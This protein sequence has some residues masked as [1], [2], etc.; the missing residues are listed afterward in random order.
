ML[1]AHGDYI[2]PENVPAN[3]FLNLEG[4]KISTSRNWA[5][6][7]HEYLVDFVDQQDAL[8][9]VLTANAPETKDNDFAWKD[10]QARNNNELLAILGNFVNRV[11]VLT[12]KYYGGK[13]PKPN[14]LL[15]VDKAILDEIVNSKKQVEA[16]L[17]VFRFRDALKEAMN[18][19]RAGNKYLTDTEP[20]KMV[21]VDP[22]RVKT[23]MYVCLQVTANL[24]VICEPFLPFT[25]KKI[26]DFLGIHDIS[27]KDAGKISFLSEGHATFEP[28]LL[29]RKIEDAE[30]Q[31]QVDK[32]HK[33]KEESSKTASVTPQ[34]EEVTFDDFGKMDIRVGTIL[35]AEKV[36]NTTKLMK[37]KIDTGIDQRTVV[38]GIAEYY[39]PDEVIGKQ[40]CILVNLK[41]RPLKGIESKG[42]ILMAQQSDGKLVFVSP[43]IITNNGA[44]VR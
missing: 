29:F 15:E 18:L 6:W 34:K 26:R 7:L 41:P 36:A 20:W 8:R 33:T 11:L 31:A 32:L 4:D 24:S 19:A 42:M 14:K 40:V 44:E 43:T 37:L 21:K 39:K 3:E 38:S 35:E 5:V 23:I 9:Y 17:D 28:S 27:W 13:V 25:A 10:F 1:K 30:I 22:E 16:Q 2:L 12:S